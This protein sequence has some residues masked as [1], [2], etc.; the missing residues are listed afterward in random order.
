MLEI[1]QSEFC[2]KLAREY[3]ADR[4]AGLTAEEALDDVAS[5]FCSNRKLVREILSAFGCSGH[6][7][8]VAAE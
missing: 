8:L 7:Q 6:G 1:V 3:E 5:R 2:A 4:R